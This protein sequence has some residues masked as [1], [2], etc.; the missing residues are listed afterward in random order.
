[1]NVEIKQP[2]QKGSP[3]DILIQKIKIAIFIFTILIMIFLV[4][5]VS[6]HQ[7]MPPNKL[8]VVQDGIT[9]QY[10]AQ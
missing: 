10:S 7:E 9:L 2:F 3:E 6:V 8:T 4:A 5:A 1:M